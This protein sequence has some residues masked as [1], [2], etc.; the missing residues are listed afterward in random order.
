MVTVWHQL[1]STRLVTNSTGVL[2]ATYTFD[3]YGG[4]ASVMWHQGQV[5]FF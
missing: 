4:L 5:S 1:G 3:S 2:Q